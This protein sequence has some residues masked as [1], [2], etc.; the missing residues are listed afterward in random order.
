[1]GNPFK[2][3]LLNRYGEPGLLAVVVLASLACR[4]AA[5]ELYPATG[6]ELA[7]YK[8]MRA[9]AETGVPWI[10]DGLLYWRSL[11]AHYLMAIPLLFAPEP[12]TGMRLV[13]VA[14]GALCLAVTWAVARQIG[15]RV[16]AVA[17]VALLFFSSYENFLV[18]S[19]RFYGPFQLF[20][21]TAAGCA[22]RYFVD[23][24]RRFFWPWFVT[25][26]LALGS[27]ELALLLFMVIA[28]ALI[29]SENRREYL[30]KH[31]V[32]ALVALLLSACL[33]VLFK[34]ANAFHNV[35][36]VPLTM[37][38]MADKL[39]F[40]KLFEKHLPGFAIGWCLALA[41]AIRAPERSFR[42]YF[43]AFTGSLLILTLVSPMENNRYVGHLFP[44]AVI[45]GVA[46]PW[47][48]LRHWWR[49]ETGWQSAA[50]TALLMMAVLGSVLGLRG[51]VAG[52]GHWQIF[53]HQEKY[54]DPRPAHDYLRQSI[55]P[56]DTIVSMESLVTEFYL[57]RPVDFLLRQR[58]NPEQR[59][60]EGFP[61][62]EARYLGSSVIDSVEK[63][64]DMSAR[65]GTVWVFVN[66]RGT[67]IDDAMKYM[68]NRNFR[69]AHVSLGGSVLVRRVPGR[70]V[71]HREE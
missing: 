56:D 65:P 29:C 55:S 25:T 17:A 16:V 34:P 70:P 40:V 20:F 21:L 24:D 11:L 31:T 3:P 7:S 63:L 6:D 41:W 48:W 62:E 8:T 69:V 54:A 5:L 47:L 68:L 14:S 53:G 51:T 67:T 59:R 36:A 43:L 49:Q 35:A 64:L 13:T 26:L 32:A 45:L 66:S 22:V 71:E 39:F 15:G 60:L 50:K 28:L 38:A 1:M 52:P 37:G 18:I 9:I 12:L 61:P 30:E 2:H 19:N 57:G 46:G 10:F 44:L 58:Y 33:L 23:G 4:L 42:C 27:H